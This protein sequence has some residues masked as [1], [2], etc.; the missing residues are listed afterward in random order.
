[1]LDTAL[2]DVAC[3]ISHQESGMSRIF[4]DTVWE[5]FK[6]PLMQIQG[7]KDS[8]GFVKHVL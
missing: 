2:G 6:G 1:M 8:S 4:N 5:V 7:A 3:R